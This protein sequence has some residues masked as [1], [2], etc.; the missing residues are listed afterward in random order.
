M[1]CEFPIA[2]G[3]R[4]CERSRCRGEVPVA[5]GKEPGRPLFPE[6]SRPRAPGP[7][8][9][10]PIA[11]PFAGRLNE[12]FPDGLPAR[13]CVSLPLSMVRTCRLEAPAA[14]AVRANTARFCT[15]ADGLGACDLI[16]E[17][18]SELCCVGLR[19][20]EFVTLAPR[21]EASV[22][23]NSPRLILWPRTKVS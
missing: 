6:A 12:P 19:P 7:A 23:W 2:E 11:P 16:F 14:G 15:A 8:R 10:S 5:P 3:G 22:T 21:N 18:P 4:F 17:S 20:T 9:R 13:P 1:R